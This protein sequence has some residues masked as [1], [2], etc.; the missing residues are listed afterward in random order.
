MAKFRFG[1][2]TLA[3]EAPSS[4]RPAMPQAQHK[5]IDPSAIADEVMSRMP[6]YDETFGAALGQ[7]R[8][9]MKHEINEARKEHSA[10]KANVESMGADMEVEM[11]SLAS[12]ME[13]M[14][15]KAPSAIIHPEVKSITH[16]KDVSKE[17]ME[18][19][20]ANKQAN[21][22]DYMNHANHI[23]AIESALRG[24]KIL[25]CILVGAVILTILSRLF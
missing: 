6:K 19:V 14:E 10:L 18:H 11:M 25:N 8:D 15:E 2:I 17:V 3:A 5:V 20:E 7:L 24:Q 9:E 4:E 23:V 21:K 12:H 1:E 22:A 16:V 13:H